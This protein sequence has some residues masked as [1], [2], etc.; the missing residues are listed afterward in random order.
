[1]EVELLPEEK[2][3]RDALSALAHKYLDMGDHQSARST[4]EDHDIIRARAIVRA[5][6][7]DRRAEK[8]NAKS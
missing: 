1:M 3:A 2:A 5:A 7:A 4:L 6:A 8:K